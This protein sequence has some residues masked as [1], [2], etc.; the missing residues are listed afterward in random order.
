MFES[1]EL[2]KFRP[3]IITVSYKIFDVIIYKDV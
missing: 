1:L 3:Q 2:N